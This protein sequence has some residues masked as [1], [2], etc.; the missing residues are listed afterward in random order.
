MYH[1]FEQAP[2]VAIDGYPENISDIKSEIKQ[3][4]VEI[5]WTI[6]LIVHR[7][8]ITEYYS[9]LDKSRDAERR[10][11]VHVFIIETNAIDSKGRSPKL[12]QRLGAFIIILILK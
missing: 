7:S 5:D 12:G 11:T 10:Y 3:N 2:A 6:Q 9:H 4:E 1:S 8:R